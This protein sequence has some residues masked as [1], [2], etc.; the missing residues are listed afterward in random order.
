VRHDAAYIEFPNGKK[1]ILVIFTRGIADD[2]TLIPAVAKNVWTEFQPL[3][4]PAP[5][6]P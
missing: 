3:T 4:P 1:M 6:T 5:R 2:L